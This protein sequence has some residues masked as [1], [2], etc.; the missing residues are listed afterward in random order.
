MDK[1]III[2]GFDDEIEGYIEFRLLNLGTKI[3]PDSFFLCKN[4]IQ[5]YFA[6]SKIIYTFAKVKPVKTLK[7]V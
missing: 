3:S 1:I 6:M 2:I 7:V 4:S 5:V